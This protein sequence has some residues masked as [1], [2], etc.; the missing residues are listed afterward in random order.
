MIKHG[1]KFVGEKAE[2]TEDGNVVAKEISKIRFTESFTFLI[3][4]HTLKIKSKISFPRGMYFTSVL[5]R[6]A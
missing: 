1:R 5:K 6:Q 3:L 2:E 4:L